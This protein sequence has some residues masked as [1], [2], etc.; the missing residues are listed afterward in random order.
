M[1]LTGDFIE[2]FASVPGISELGG[3]GIKVMGG[4]NYF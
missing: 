4:M 3:G 2:L 1:K